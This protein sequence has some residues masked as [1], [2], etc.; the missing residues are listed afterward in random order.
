MICCHCSTALVECPSLPTKSRPT[1]V[2]WK[3]AMQSLRKT[4]SSSNR[5]S[6]RSPCPF[7]IQLKAKSVAMLKAMR[8][9]TGSLC[10]AHSSNTWISASIRSMTKSPLNWKMFSCEHRMTLASLWV[11]IL[12]PTQLSI[13]FTDKLLRCTSR[14]A[15]IWD[16]QMVEITRL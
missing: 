16:K 4:K 12:S 11:A 15:W 7:S 6:L 10:A 8:R 13:V 1:R 14:D 5:R 3:S 2:S 9:Q